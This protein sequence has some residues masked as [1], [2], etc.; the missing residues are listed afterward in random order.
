MILNKVSSAIKNVIIS[1]GLYASSR[2]QRNSWSDSHSAHRLYVGHWWVTVWH[3]ACFSWGHNPSSGLLGERNRFFPGKGFGE[4]S[5]QFCQMASLLPK[6][7]PHPPTSHFPPLPPP[8]SG[9][10]RSKFTFFGLQWSQ[11]R[12]GLFGNNDSSSWL[13]GTDDRLWGLVHVRQ[14]ILYARGK[15]LLTVEMSSALAGWP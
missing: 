14:T 6:G 4:L 13:W 10:R 3:C 15:F 12:K 2:I 7:P 11:L 9:R 5:S 1:R 8:S